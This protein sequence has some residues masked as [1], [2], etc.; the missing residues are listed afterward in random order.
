M[1]ADS[2][3]AGIVHQTIDLRVFAQPVDL[4]G[5]EIILGADDF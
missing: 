4:A 3:G 1:S 2:G 5:F